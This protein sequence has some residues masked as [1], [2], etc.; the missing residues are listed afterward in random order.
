VATDAEKNQSFNGQLNKGDIGQNFEKVKKIRQGAPTSQNK[1]KK[2][3]NFL[4][5]YYLSAPRSVRGVKR[6]GRT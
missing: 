5:L 3:I 6:T 2:I 1:Q 4:Y